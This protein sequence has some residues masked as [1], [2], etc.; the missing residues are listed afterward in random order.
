MEIYILAMFKNEGDILKEWIEHYK[1]FGINHIYLINDNSTDN[2]LEICNQYSDLVTVFNID[3]NILD[4]KGRQVS[5]YNKYFNF[6]IGQPAWAL[7]CD[8]DEFIF[9][10]L[11]TTFHEVLITFNVNHITMPA[12]EFGFNSDEQ[13]SEIVN[14]CILRRSNSL[15]ID[16]DGRYYMK[17]FVKLNSIK[18][19]KSVHHQSLDKSIVICNSNIIRFNHYPLQS[20]IHIIKRLMRGGG[21]RYR[22]PMI[23]ESAENTYNNTDWSIYNKVEDTL[24]IE[25]YKKMRNEQYKNIGLIELYISLNVRP[26]KKDAATDIIKPSIISSRK[27]T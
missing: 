9:P 6:L 25:T 4:V 23:K 5:A 13:P 22:L 20:K 7:V 11:S 26:E 19:F 27:F 2:G 15:Y 1:L 21:D 8:I 17:S 24:L 16:K 18:E 12:Y 14:N 10:V 3:P